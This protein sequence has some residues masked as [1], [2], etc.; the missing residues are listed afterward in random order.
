MTL[1]IIYG[2]ISLIGSFLCSIWEAVLLSITPSYAETLKQ[3]KPGVAKLVEDF[4]GN[5]DRPLSAILTLN[6]IAHTVGAILVGAQATKLWGESAIELLGFE[7]PVNGII[8]PTFMTLVILI[9]SE[10][11]PKT[12]GANYW[13]ALTP[14]TIRSLNFV[15][16]IL[17]PLVWF[18]QQITK[19]LKKNKGESVFSRADFTAMARIG[20]KE[21]VIEEDESNIIMNLLKFKSVK[22]TDI[23]T[24]RTVVKAASEETLIQDFYKENQNLRFSRIPIYEQ[25]KDNITGFFLKDKMLDALINEQGEKPLTTIK[26]NI[27]IVNETFPLPELFN[28]FMREREHIAL[29]VDEFGGMAGIVTM[30]DAIE[31]L[32]GMEIVDELDSTTDMQALARKNWE[33]RAKNLGIIED[34]G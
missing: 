14:F 31:T 18:S 27:M 23:M 11:I 13:K 2:L 25:S 28:R 17:T 20:T 3:T 19:R 6:T 10:I 8:V 33:K 9:L 22:T 21:G 16:L 5:V 34:Q 32:L 12:L 30:E 15:I 26:R 1:L 7:I 29:V 24:P 4:K